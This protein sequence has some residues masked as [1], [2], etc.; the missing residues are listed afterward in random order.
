MSQVLLLLLDGWG[1][2]PL[3]EANAFTAAKT[4]TFFDLVKEYPVALLSPGRQSRNARYLSL[5]AGREISDEDAPVKVSLAAVLAAA[6]RTQSKISETER[7][8]A[9]TYF[10]NGHAEDRVSGESWKIISSA[11][12]NQPVKPLLALKRTVKEILAELTSDAAP[13]LIVAAMPYLDLVAQTGDLA[14]VKE[15]IENLDKYLRQIWV[16]SE[17]QDR[18]L[19]IS[20]ASGNVERIR[21]LALESVDAQMTDSP[22]PLIIAG[23]SFKGRT[24]GLAEPLSS[25]LSLLEP[26]GTLADLAPTILDIMGLAKTAEMTG[27]SLL[28]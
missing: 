22:V 5:G 26:A 18:V 14:L 23:P 7:F 28:S 3:S 25:D 9:L 10:F 27:E 24:I 8:A 2:A 21:N 12:G 6:G 20:A 11:A 16:A 17:A 1:V 19:V 4:P 15:A 13:D